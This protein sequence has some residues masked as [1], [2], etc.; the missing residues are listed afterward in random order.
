[1]FDRIFST[2]HSLSQHLQNRKINFQK[3]V[4]L[5]SAAIETVEVFHQDIEWEIIL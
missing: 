3:A 2:L 1:M 4:D 5:V